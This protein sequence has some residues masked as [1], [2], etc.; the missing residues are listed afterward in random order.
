MANQAKIH[1]CRIIPVVCDVIG[2]KAL[3][4]GADPVRRGVPYSV[5]DG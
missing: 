2:W 3:A 4:E 5:S 1:D